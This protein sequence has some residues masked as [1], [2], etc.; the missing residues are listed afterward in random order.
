VAVSAHGSVFAQK[1]SALCINHPHNKYDAP[2]LLSKEVFSRTLHYI[3]SNVLQGIPNN[4]GI[5]GIPLQGKELELSKY[6]CIFP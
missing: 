2:S 1:K 4:K 5:P 3:S 6:I